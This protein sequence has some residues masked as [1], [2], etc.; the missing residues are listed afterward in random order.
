MNPQ[1]AHPGF[2]PA[3]PSRRQFLRTAGLGAGSLALTQLLHSEGLLAGQAP[4][5]VV[6]PLAPK[7]PH[8]APKAKAVIWLFMTGSPSQVDTFDYKPELQKRNGQTL[9]GADP[10]TGFFTTSGK[11]LKSPFQWKQHGKSGSWVSDVF[12]KTAAYVD[13]MAFIHSCYTRAN[14]HAPGAYEISCGVTRPGLP[15]MGSWVTYGLGSEARNLPAFVVMH[16]TKPRGEDSIWSA[17]FLPKNFQALAMDGRTPKPI[18]HLDRAAGVSDPQ[19][20]AALDL[21]RE[22]NQ[23]HRTAHPLESELAARVE[24][25]ELAYRMQTAAPE[26]FDLARETDRVRNLYGVGDKDADVFGRQCLT[27]RRLVERGVRFVQIFAGRGVGG[28]GSVGDVP[29]DGHNNIETNHRSCGRACDRPIAALLGDLKARGLLEDT[30]VVW[31]GEFG[32]TSD[33][34]DSL[35]R[36]HNPNAFTVWMAGGGVKGGTHYGATDEFGYKAVENRTSVHDLHATILHLLGI[37]HEKLTYR[38]NARD[39][40]L[41]DVSGTVIREILA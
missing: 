18:A 20:R 35:G 23:N 24:S 29:W 32:R 4:P 37:N 3:V 11:C 15:C 27:A 36:D 38:F 9:A 5:A 33:S 25:F 21:L 8:F 10:K 13:D 39:Y 41:T 34:Q 40:R 12:E 17:G 7:K 6:D 22:M 1:F 19:Q 30:L 26:A 28:D 16:E 31:S 14:N 2:G